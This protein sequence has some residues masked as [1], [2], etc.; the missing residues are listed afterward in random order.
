MAKKRGRT[1]RTKSVQAQY[2]SNMDFSH[3]IAGWRSVDDKNDHGS[4]LAA[5]RAIKAHCVKYHTNPKDREFRIIT[6]VISTRIEGI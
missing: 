5:R 4:K 1:T 6:T 2:Y 3:E